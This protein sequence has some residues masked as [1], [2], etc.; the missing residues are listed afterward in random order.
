[1][2][3]ILNNIFKSEHYSLESCIPKQ[4]VNVPPFPQLNFKR[5]ADIQ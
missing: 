2:A 5:D 3:I 4:A 1:M